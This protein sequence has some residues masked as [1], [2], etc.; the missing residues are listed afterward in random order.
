MTTCRTVRICVSTRV[1]HEAKFRVHHLAVRFKP[2]W[3]MSFSGPL[4]HVD[5][6][7]LDIL[8]FVLV[9]V[10]FFF[11]SAAL[12][13]WHC[14]SHQG[15]S[16]VPKQQPTSLT[17]GGVSVEDS[18]KRAEPVRPQVDE[19]CE[20]RRECDRVLSATNDENDVE[21][22]GETDDEDMQDGEMGFDDGS[23]QVRNIRYPGQP[24][25]KELQQHMTA[26]RPYRSWCKFT[27]DQTRKTTWRRYRV[28]QWTVGPLGRGNRKSRCSL[29]WSSANGGTR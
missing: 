14:C 8:C 28:C 25:S 17:A 16:H 1:T 5:L 22:N 9:S 18:S 10:F 7:L 19:R 26:H 23:V 2:R 21:L 3:W 24:T 6:V 13:T 11:F 15:S 29:C 27:E 12:V 4:L 20:K